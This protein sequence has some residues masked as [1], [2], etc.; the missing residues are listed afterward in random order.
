MKVFVFDTIPYDH[1]FDEFKADRHI[2][3]P[4]PRKYFDPEI[5][6][7]TYS[8]H[9]EVWR[10][11]DRLGYDGVEIIRK[12]WTEETFSHHGKFW[13]FEDVAIWPR[14]Y[15]SPHTPVWV[16]FTGSKETIEWAGRNNVNAVVTAVTPGLTE[17]IV[18]EYATAL[19]SH[20]H[21]M[22]P[23]KLC[24]FTDVW[25]A[26][27]KAEA[28]KEFGPYV[29]YFR[30]TLWHHDTLGVKN[31]PSREG[32]VSRNSYDYIRPENRAAAALDRE[33]IRPTTMADIETNVGNGTYHWGSAKEVT[34]QLIE[35]A[36]HAG[37]NALLV[38][39]DLGAVPHELYLEQIR[40]FGGEVLPQLQAHQVTRARRPAAR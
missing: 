17:D 36:E 1:H 23:E 4:L 30:Q 40:R 18:G 38:N 29:L 39:M 22:T 10:E 33:K 8:A 35:L 31:A 5:A 32:F 14:P 3:Y 20:G 6:A 19:E 12:A 13:S 9:I 27:S 28:V 34:E 37:A 2:P 16:P 26:G 15:Q 7:R 11:M 24:M 21:R 25:V